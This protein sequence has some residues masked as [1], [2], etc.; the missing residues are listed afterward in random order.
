LIVPF[1]YKKAGE[2]ELLAGAILNDNN[3]AWAGQTRD[4]GIRGKG[5]LRTFCVLNPKFPITPA[6][7]QGFFSNLNVG[8]SSD[9]ILWAV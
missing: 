5:I 7:L 4:P 6:I 9:I 2:Q 3:K 8:H 1:L